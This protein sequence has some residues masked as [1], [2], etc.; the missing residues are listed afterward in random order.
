MPIEDQEIGGEMS[1]IP[2]PQGLCVE[3]W[4]GTYEDIVEDYH[5]GWET[6]KDLELHRCPKCGHTTL[7]WQSVERVDE[8][9]VKHQQQKELK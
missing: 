5:I 8:I 3:C 6:I 9:L 2:P 4:K 1:E 7:P